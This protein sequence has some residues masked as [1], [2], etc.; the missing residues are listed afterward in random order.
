MGCFRLLAPVNNAAVNV[1]EPRWS[2]CLRVLWVSESPGEELL[3]PRVTPCSL[4]RACQTTAVPGV[5]SP[6]AWSPAR[7]KTEGP[8]PRAVTARLDLPGDCFLPLPLPQLLLPERSSP[9]SRNP[10]V[11]PRGSLGRIFGRGA[12]HGALLTPGWAGVPPQCPTFA[13]IPPQH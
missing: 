13:S 2:L 4:L 7:T 6:L 11:A 9:N 10:H 8:G 12:F 3:G 5:R 1:S